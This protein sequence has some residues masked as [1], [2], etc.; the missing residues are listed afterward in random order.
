MMLPVGDLK[1]QSTQC[2]QVIHSFNNC[3]LKAPAMC[4]AI[5][6]KKYS[7]NSCLTLPLIKAK[8]ITFNYTQQI[9]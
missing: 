9:K 8:D 1:K 2:L 3:L 4:T 7:L 6:L 5:S